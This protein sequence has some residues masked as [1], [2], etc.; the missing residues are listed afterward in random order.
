MLARILASGATVERRWNSW[1]TESSGFV[2]LAAPGPWQSFR[3]DGKMWPG[4]GENEI[5][6]PGGRHQISP[7]ESQFRIVDRSILDLRMLRFVGSLDSL[8]PTNRGLE[9]TYDSNSRSMA[10]FNRQPFG[11]ATF[12]WSALQR[13]WSCPL[14]NPPMP[15]RQRVDSGGFPFWRRPRPPG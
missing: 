5:L 6:I 4:W 3:V 12:A 13:A 1:V 7:E 14:P 2:Q 15:P 8:T 10:L 9:F 11:N